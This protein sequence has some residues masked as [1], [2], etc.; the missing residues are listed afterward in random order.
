[1]VLGAAVLGVTVPM[2]GRVTTSRDVAAVLVVGAALQRTQERQ[3]QSV[4][5]REWPALPN[6]LRRPLSTWVAVQQASPGGTGGGGG[7]S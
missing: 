6:S 4:A 5:D 2:T 7:R 3:H 1:M